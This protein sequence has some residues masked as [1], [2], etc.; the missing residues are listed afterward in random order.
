[1]GGRRERNLT[2]RYAVVSDIHANRTA[3]RAVEERVRWLRREG[4]I[5]YWFLGDLV[6]YGPTEQAVQCL[7]WLRSE[8]GIA[9][10]EETGLSQRWVPGNHDE[11]LVSPTGPL[12]DEAQVTLRRQ[13]ERFRQSDC[14]E[15]A[16]WFKKIVEAAV[17]PIPAPEAGLPDEETQSL[18]IE[19][20]TDITL[21]FVHA[22]VSVLERRVTYL[23]ALKRNLIAED[24][25]RLQTMVSGERLCL[26]YGHTHF[27]L[28]AR[29]NPDGFDVTFLPIKYGDPIPLTPGCYAINPGSVGQPRDGD[30]RAAFAVVD[31]D[32]GTIEFRR[33]DYDLS[34]VVSALNKEQNSKTTPNERQ[35]YKCLVE[36]LVNANGKDD[37]Q[38]YQQIYRIPKWDLEVVSNDSGNG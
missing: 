10:D 24:L 15:D 31:T 6:G 30:P 35:V 2:V 8:S 28:L 3:L 29:L 36:R 21:A 4:D 33:V 27:P 13:I 5:K 7:R 34:E 26:F 23:H 22:S 14:L 38:N 12:A 17:R 11:W 37:L 20:H 9:F 32:A 25:R 16:Q 1:M 18:V 19:S